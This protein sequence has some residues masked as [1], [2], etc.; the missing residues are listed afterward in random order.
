MLLLLGC[1]LSPADATDDGTP[2]SCGHWMHVSCLA[3]YLEV[4]IGDADEGLL[5]NRVEF[6]C[7]LCRSWCT[8]G[9]PLRV[10]PSCDAEC[11]CAAGKPAH[12]TVGSALAISGLAFLRAT[13]DKVSLLSSPECEQLHAQCRKAAWARFASTGAEAPKLPDIM[14][15]CE[16]L[17][18]RDAQALTFSE[19]PLRH[20][21]ALTGHLHHLQAVLTS[22]TA[23]RQAD[24]AML[25]QALTQPTRVPGGCGF[26]WSPLQ[27]LLLLVFRGEPTWS[28][29]ELHEMVR[30]LHTVELALACTRLASMHQ[31][32]QNRL[33]ALE[34]TASCTVDVHLFREGNDLSDLPLLSEVT[35]S[36]PAT[37]RE[38]GVTATFTF[39]LRLMEEHGEPAATGLY[40]QFAP[41][42]ASSGPSGRSVFVC[43]EIPNF[44]GRGS[45]VG[46]I[47]LQEGATVLLA[48]SAARDDL[49]DWPSRCCLV[50]HFPPQ[51]SMD[52]GKGTANFR[53]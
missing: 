30:M 33:C 20:S 23:C 15:L 11:T 49:S 24:V 14:A 12:S 34:A 43:V 42:Q 16:R 31:S 2:F 19:A 18:E 6:R 36:P 37:A 9:L 5:R 41:V 4:A 29:E 10:T 32:T 44:D 22:C 48:M 8:A 26:S 17:L 50:C 53:L 21:S 39:T 46:P 13:L 35:C 28:V 52:R 27:H 47:R 7:P 1:F 25:N 38:D 45:M 40:L 3:A 51:E